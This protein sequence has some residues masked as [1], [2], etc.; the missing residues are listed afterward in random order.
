[1]LKW[2]VMITVLFLILVLG[3]VND[4]LSVYSVTHYIDVV[5]VSTIG[6][7]LLFVYVVSVF[8]TVLIH[9]N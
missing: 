4:A 8:V 5:F 6:V 9:K 7:A 3:L 2:L 1:M